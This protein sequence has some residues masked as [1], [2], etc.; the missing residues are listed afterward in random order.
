MRHDRSSLQRIILGAVLVALVAAAIAG[1]VPTEETA[2][3]REARMAWWRDAR[4]GMF[5]HFGLFSVAAGEWNGRPVPGLGEWIM[6]SGQIRLA[7]YSV[8]QKQFN[9]VK[10]NARMWAKIAKDAGMKYVVLTTK[11]IDGFCMFGSKLTDYNV[12]NT[13]FKRDVLKELAAA[14]RREGL[15]MGTY[16]SISDFAYPD[17]CPLGPGSTWA[18]VVQEKK[19][20]DF[21][22]YLSYL[23]GQLH[24]LLTNYG[25]IG[26]MWFDACYDQSPEQIHAAEL[27][28]MMRGI[29]P[30]LI[31]NN[32]LGVPLDFD[33][34]EQEIP[35]TGI[36]DRDWETCMTIND[37]WG[38]KKQDH[39]WKSTETLVKN[40]IDAV[41]KG[42]NYLLNVGPTGE[43]EIPPECVDRL[44]EIGRWMNVNGEAIYGTTASPFKK[45]GWGRCTQKEGKLYLH[46]YDWPAGELV[47]P[48]LRNRVKDAYLLADRAKS[49]LTVTRTADEVRIAV[50]QTAPDKIAS[51]VVL[52]ID[53][54]AIVAP[55][56][57]RQAADGSLS[58]QAVDATIHGRTAKLDTSPGQD[59]VGYWTN[60]Q[61]WVSWDCAFHEPGTFDVEVTYACT[62]ENAGSDFFVEVA[63]VQLPGKVQSTGGWGKFV[64][65]KLGS[66]RIDTAGARP[67]FVQASAM[68]HGAVMNLKTVTLK[69]KSQ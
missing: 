11:H 68:P 6:V 53:G 15:K 24:E 64:T 58:L 16:Y 31:V 55:V 3:Q 66:V 25:P 38:F 29:Q 13:P 10:F 49:P 54:P 14:V 67:V 56:P 61:D 28:K 27:V 37:T 69:P 51:V 26:V 63:G 32:R 1:Q 59:D 4:F 12:V 8:L 20:P 22:K 34:P 33:T 43:G 39:N 57:I 36:P 52:D 65:F 19:N 9:P 48:G 40:L 2:Q 45:L 35:S 47:V 18:T 41:S 62:D 23:K 42:G 46:V 17:Y 44:R 30:D 50:P 21:N 7:D 60:V 5:I